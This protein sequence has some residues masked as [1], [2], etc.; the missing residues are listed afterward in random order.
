MIKASDLFYKRVYTKTGQ[1]LGLI[2]NVHVKGKGKQDIKNL[3]VSI[4]ACGS[5]GFLERI[6]FREKRELKIPWNAVLK[7]EKHKVIVKDLFN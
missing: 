5:R 7:V 2:F 4:L 6:G 1:D 3:K